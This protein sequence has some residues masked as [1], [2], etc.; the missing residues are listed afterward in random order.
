MPGGETVTE[1]RSRR[2]ARRGR[3]GGWRARRA[4]E[5]GGGDQP[6]ALGTGAPD[7]P[8]RVGCQLTVDLNGSHGRPLAR[9]AAGSEET[10][11]AL[12]PRLTYSRA[13]LLAVRDR[14]DRGVDRGVTTTIG[15]CLPARAPHRRCLTEPTRQNENNNDGAAAEPSTERRLKIAHLNV[16]H[17]MPSIDEV[18]VMLEKYDLDILCLSETFLN[19]DIDSRFLMFPGYIVERLDRKSH[20]GGVCVIYRDAMR[21]D[22]VN[23]PTTG[24]ALEALW[25]S[26]GGRS[27]FML[28]TLY[29]PPKSPVTPVLNDLQGQL[30]SILVHHQPTYILGDLNLD[31]SQ[32]ATPG[33][34]RYL[35]ILDELSLTQLI[36]TPTRTTSTSATII[37]H[38]IVS[39]QDLVSCPRVISCDI[40]DHDVI[41]VD[42]AQ[43]RD[44][45][46]AP[47][48]TIR[49]SKY[50]DSNALCLDL[51]QADWSSVYEA[52]TA[53]QKWRAWL[54]V[55]QPHMDHHMPLKI[56]KL[57]HPP[58]PWLQDNEEL[59]ECMRQRD[60]ARKCRDKDQGNDEKLQKYRDCRNAVK[61]VV[62]YK[63]CSAYY[64]QS[65]E[66]HK[67]KTWTD[68]RRF[69]IAA[70][71]PEPKITPSHQS[72]AA[73]ADK[74]NRHFV[75]AGA[76]VASALTAAPQGVALL[77]RPPRVCAGSF[78]VR[79]VTLPQLS[80]A[81]SRM[82]NSN[83][84]AGDEITVNM[85]RKTF[86]VVGPHLCHLVN[87]SL[88]TGEVPQGWKEALVIPLF[89]Q[90]NR[91]N[92][93]N[94]RPIS[95]LSVVG[96]LCEKVVCMQLSEYLKNH[97]ILSPSQHGFR[98]NHSTETA[99]LET[100]SYLTKSIDQGKVS[101]LLA[102]DTSKAFDTV[103]HGRL[104]D[105]L[106]WYGIDAHWFSNWL[107]HRTQKI[108]GSNTEA[109]P[110]THGVIQGSLLGPILFSIF[111]NDLVSHVVNGKLI[112]YADDC[113]FLDSD[114]PR[115]LSVL[116]Q[117]VE[118]TLETALNWFTQNRLKINP[119]KTE[120]L[121]VKSRQRNVETFSIMFGENEIAPGPHAKKFGVYIDSALNW[122][123]Q[124]S[125]V[126]RRC[127]AILFG[128]SKL[129]NKIPVETKKLLVQALVFPLIF[130]CLPAWGGCVKIQGERIQKAIN[131]GARVVTGVRKRDHI[132]PA[133]EAL[134]WLRFGGIVE[135]RDLALMKRLLHSVHPPAI[136][137]TILRRSD[138]SRKATRGTSVDK[139]QLPL[140]NTELAKR[141]FPYR[142]ISTWNSKL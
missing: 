114:L 69:L 112:M 26:F 4:R 89:K 124:V 70:K 76:E 60:V 104:I 77:P 46:R 15:R 115:H 110:V 123:K 116:K 43:K 48:I 75:A 42:I 136:A 108:R 78:R 52:D 2:P 53:E 72:D 130:Y 24:S 141:S 100:V 135:E 19:S 33:V 1:A 87:C 80:V 8:C 93:S 7:G 68:I 101:T 17:L 91:D 67:S 47:N 16:C 30:T 95:I 64:A 132:T 34:K 82:G 81:L 40:S 12:T 23:I 5:R 85:L 51:L 56:V 39:R 66:R 9:T 3:R 128:L 103:E 99:L 79:S 129:R 45:R 63:S 90:G 133:L 106:G 111:T 44:R 59:K 83:A 28:G 137:D 107:D 29:R 55:W 25:M 96:K 35:E 21:G 142:A 57:K 98:P 119:C 127:Y 140:V 105:K 11:T 71:K 6:S 31:V 102:A 109:L 118:D 58:C 139:L 62:Q 138:V 41:A 92:P 84:S 22:T 97:G 120:L 74:L 131:F 27:P 121:I 10:V 125:Q 20:G 134:D 32:P 13:Q 88:R 54:A 37:D 122:E 73:W 36:K 50:V 94:Y 61:R 14:S 49:S 117:R 86:A 126:C 65:Y 18:N 113:Q 38:V